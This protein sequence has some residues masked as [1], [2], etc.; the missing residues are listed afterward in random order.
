MLIKI[1]GHVI[2]ITEEVDEDVLTDKF[3]DFM[4]FNGWAFTG[5]IIKDQDDFVPQVSDYIDEDITDDESSI[6]YLMALQEKYFAEGDNIN[7]AK[8]WKQIN[9]LLDGT[10]DVV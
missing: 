7:H 6:K 9:E 2:G 3:L 1:E 4:K 8:C 5:Q 10:K